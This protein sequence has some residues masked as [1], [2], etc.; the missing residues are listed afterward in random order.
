VWVF[1]GNWEALNPTTAPSNR[2]S[3]LVYDRSQG[4]FI[5]FGGCSS[6]GR[7][8]CNTPGNV[9]GDTFESTIPVFVLGQTA[10]PQLNWSAPQG[11]IGCTL[12]QGQTA[13]SSPSYSAPSAGIIV[14]WDV[15]GPTDLCTNC[16]A[17]LRVFRPTGT[18]GQF[19][20]IAET[21]IQ[22][23]D[24]GLKSFEAG[25]PVQAGDILGVDFTN[26]IR[27]SSGIAG[28]AIYFVSGDPGVGQTTTGPTCGTGACWFTNNTNLRANVVAIF[29]A[30][31]GP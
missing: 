3:A 20:T 15:Q 29:V 10:P 18:P 24:T 9:L 21:P 19:L 4:K 17:K 22:T 30:T 7:Y 8:S 26:G 14:S 28:D 2:N 12:F 16:T 27:W 6:F 25:I 23:I 1:D 5:L 31:P 11:C 13:A